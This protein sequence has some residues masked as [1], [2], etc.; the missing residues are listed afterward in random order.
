MWQF[1]G[2]KISSVCF[3]RAPSFSR[4]HVGSVATCVLETFSHYGLQIYVCV[5]VN[6]SGGVINKLVL[7]QAVAWN[8]A[9]HT[10]TSYQVP[11]TFVPLR[12]IEQQQVDAR[13]IYAA[14]RKDMCGEFLNLRDSAPCSEPV[15]CIK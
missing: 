5:H 6:Y 2:M 7:F 8:A 1:C 13:C 4:P 10:H 9:V 3:S 14:W 15:A 12:P 11:V